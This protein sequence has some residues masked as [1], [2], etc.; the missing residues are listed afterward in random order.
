[1]ANRF[2]EENRYRPDFVS[3]PGDT[4]LETIETIGMPQVELAKRMGRPPKTINGIIKGTVA[5]TPE[6]ALQLE[7]VLGVSA[8]FWNNRESNY[9]DFLAREKAEAIFKRYVEWLKDIPVKAMVKAGWIEKFK[10]GTEQVQE[11]LRFFGVAS[12]NQWRKIWN[13]RIAFRRSAIYKSDPG[14]V[15]AWLRMGELRAQAIDCTPFSADEFRKTLP[16]IRALTRRPPDVFV[17]GTVNLCRKAGVAVVFV[18]QLP[19]ARASGASRWLTPVKALIQVS[20][21]Y[22]TEDQLWFTF[23]H[24]AGHVL[25][26]EKKPIFLDEDEP[27]GNDEKD[28]DEFAANWLIPMEQLR[29]FVRRH[30]LSKAA[31]MK[32]AEEIR[33]SPGIVVGRLQHERYLPFS[34][35]ND[36][37]A[38]L[39][40]ASD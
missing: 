38:R 5:I 30:N 40:W 34:H 15:A 14:A 2:A 3:P 7:R 6:T 9:R 11:V 8:S 28:A 31:I 24:E 26:G 4:L 25:R 20:L 37:K 17:P 23:F 35:C 18:P 27:N 32:F 39:F 1:M 22:K 12:P 29:R 19:K 10:D 16:E 33:V 36:L 13:V 21:R